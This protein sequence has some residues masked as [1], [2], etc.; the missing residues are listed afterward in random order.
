[1][2]KLVNLLVVIGILLLVL[3]MGGKFIGKP[4]IVMGFKVMNIIVL[5]NSALLLALI[6]K[7]A[8]KK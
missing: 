6:A 1:M 8:E 4:G 2:K 3:A 5:A 7:T